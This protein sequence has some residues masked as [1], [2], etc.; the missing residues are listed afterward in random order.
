M[1][2][3]I[4]IIALGIVAGAPS[5][6]GWGIFA[7]SYDM[8]KSFTD[9]LT[10]TTM[11]MAFDGTSYWSSSGGSSDGVRYAQYDSSGAIV[12]TYSPGL[13]FRSVF[14]LGSTVLARQYSSSDIYVQTTPGTF[15]VG[16]TLAGGIP[17]PQ[18]AVVLGMNDTELDAFSSGILSKWDGS[19]NYLG[20]VTFVGFGTMGT[21]SNYPSY[22]G[23]AGW[24]SYYVTYDSGTIYGWD[25]AG[26][27]VG[28]AVLNGAGTGFASNFSFS[29]AGDGRFWVVDQASGTWRGYNVPVP[30][31]ATIAVAAI[32]ALALLRRRKRA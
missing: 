25:A 15:V 5:A 21:E 9:A 8:D 4:T 1:K 24:G 13:D 27:R 20:A 19:G 7:D 28:G 16:T 2:S 6:F 14:T 29:Y 12:N 18:S 11:T 10:D 17:D 31:P 22:R 26:N 30:E 23:V 32:G 3:R